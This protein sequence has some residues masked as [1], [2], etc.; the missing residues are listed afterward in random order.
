M[1]GTYAALADVRRLAGG[2]GSISD[3]DMGDFLEYGNFM[4]EG[5]TGLTDVSISDPRY[6]LMTQGADYYASSAVRDHFSDKQKMADT[7]FNRAKEICASIIALGSSGSTSARS[8][9]QGY[10]TYP[11]NPEGKYFSNEYVDFDGSSSIFSDN[12]MV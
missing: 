4:I 12:D 3:S 6:A 11:L 7:H 1:V 9:S 10:M 2:V 8:V 5:C